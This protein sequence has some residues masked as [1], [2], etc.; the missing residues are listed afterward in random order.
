MAARKITPQIP[1]DTAQV[2]EPAPIPEAEESTAPNDGGE[3]SIT[4]SK[5]DLQAL[6]A[7][8]VQAQVE[9]SVVSQVGKARGSISKPLPHQSEVDATT[10]KRSVLTTEGYVV[11]V[12]SQG[13]RIRMQKQAEQAKGIA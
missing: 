3:D 8:Q 1:G 2:E 10:I 12:I 5:S 7:D 4:L 6:I 9:R 13:D 11:P